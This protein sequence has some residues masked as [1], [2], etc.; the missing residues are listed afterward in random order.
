[1]ISCLGI[2][3]LYFTFTRWE[4]THKV[5]GC[6]VKGL[7]SLLLFLFFP[8][9]FH[10][11]AKNMT[12]GTILL[13]AIPTEMTARNANTTAALEHRPADKPNKQSKQDNK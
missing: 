3:D 2:D 1:M 5:T 12:D 11:D 13:F 7:L 6:S 10:W 4:W 8:L 9:P